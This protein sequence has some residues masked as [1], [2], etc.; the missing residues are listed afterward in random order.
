MNTTT[1]NPSGR[2]EA[3][4]CQRVTV[5]GMTCS[6]C[7]HATAAELGAIAGVINVTA[8]AATGTITIDAT[9]QLEINEIAAAVDNA[10]YEL[11]R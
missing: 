2:T 10:G 8:D 9:R 11:A 6:H 3:I 1:T 5:I 7:E 4:V